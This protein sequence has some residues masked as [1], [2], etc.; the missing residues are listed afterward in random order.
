MSLVVVM[1]IVVMI[2]VTAR[3]PIVA[4]SVRA[5]APISVIVAIKFEA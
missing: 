5:I 3:S 4:A 1:T 2:M